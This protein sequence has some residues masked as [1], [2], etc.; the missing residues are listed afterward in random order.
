MDNGGEYIRKE[1][2]HIC[3][4]LGITHET[5]SLYTPEHNGIAKRHDRTLQERALAL[6]H[7]ADLSGKFWVS[8]IYTVNFVKNQVLHHQLGISPY[9]AFW[10]KKPS[11]DWL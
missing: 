5:T 3:S 9:E 8:A 4:K 10:E 1:F 2:A 6:Q 7:N 11:I